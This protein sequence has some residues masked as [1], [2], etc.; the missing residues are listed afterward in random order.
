[1]C[2]NKRGKWESMHV[3]LYEKDD[4]DGVKNIQKRRLIVKLCITF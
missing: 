2:N 1:M 3:E 4:D